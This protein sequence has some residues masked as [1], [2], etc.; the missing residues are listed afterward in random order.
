MHDAIRQKPNGADE[1]NTLWCSQP[2]ITEDLN[3]TLSFRNI[4]PSTHVND[5]KDTVSLRVT[6]KKLAIDCRITFHEVL[7]FK[8]FLNCA[9]VEPGG[10]FFFLKMRRTHFQILCQE[11]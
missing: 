5:A 1:C 11:I 9:T 7:R 3:F 10:F 2:G 8:G 6:G 4:L